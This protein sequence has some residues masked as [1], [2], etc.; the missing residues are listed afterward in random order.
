MIDSGKEQEQFSCIA[1][2]L[3]ESGVQAKS[4]PISG[5]TREVVLKKAFDARPSG[6]RLSRI[7]PADD[8]HRNLWE[9]GKGWL[10][11]LEEQLRRGWN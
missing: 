9:S 2:Y 1:I 6:K 10:P 8:P 7:V 3:P 4:I 11:T 5:P